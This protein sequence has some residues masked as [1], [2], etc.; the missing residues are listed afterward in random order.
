MLLVS[1]F[2]SPRLAL[3]RTFFILS[4]GRFGDCWKRSLTFDPFSYAHWR[5]ACLIVLLIVLL[6][7]IVEMFTGCD[8]LGAG[9]WSEG[10]RRFGHGVLD[11]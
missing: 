3:V 5:L 10:G 9:R 7:G 1:F 6:I 4:Q 2:L 8:G 11:N